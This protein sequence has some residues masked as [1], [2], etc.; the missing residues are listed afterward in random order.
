MEL[1]GRLLFILELVVSRIH[2]G[3]QR[4]MEVVGKYV[5]RCALMNSSQSA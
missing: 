5:V 1:M 3:R 4:W 2:F